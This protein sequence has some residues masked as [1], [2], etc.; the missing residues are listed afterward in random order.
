MQVVDQNL[1]LE[2]MKLGDTRSKFCSPMLVNS[3]LALASVSQ[4][5]F[6]SWPKNCAVLTVI[7]YIRI[8]L[9]YMAPR[10][11]YILEVSISSRKQRNSGRPK[12]VDLHWPIFRLWL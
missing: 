2:H 12:R 8:I 10:E 9:R 7:R 1:F 3:I 11:T 4:S 5:Q 6:Q